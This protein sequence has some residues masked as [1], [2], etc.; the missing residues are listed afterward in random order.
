MA[1]IN[2]TGHWTSSRDIYKGI[3]LQFKLEMSK[4]T[5]RTKEEVL[6]DIRTLAKKDRKYLNHKKLRKIGYGN[7]FYAAVKHFGTWNE[8]ILASGV[9]PLYKKWSKDKVIEEIKGIYEN[10][11]KVPNNGELKRNGNLSLINA[12]YIYWGCWTNAIKAAGFKPYRNDYWTKE[13]LILELKK[14]VS[15]IGHAPSKRELNRFGRFDLVSS[16]SKI[17][18]GYSNYLIAAGFEPVLIPNI[19]TKDRIKEEIIKLSQKIRRTPTERD[20]V[21][22]GLGT[23]K[24]AA[25]R[26]FKSWNAAVK[27]AGLLPNENC[28]KDKIWKEWELFVLS[29]CNYLHPNSKKHIMFPNKCIPDV[30]EPNAKLVIE[31]KINAS[32]STI[33]K[34]IA[35]YDSYC[36]KIEIWHLTGKPIK[37]RSTKVKFVGPNEIRDLIFNNKTFLNKFDEIKNKLEVNQCEA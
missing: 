13:D 32:D 21:S 24:M 14:A 23:V 25:I 9:K 5:I 28:V 19:W 27:S 2:T 10:T 18:G 3:L 31:V 11:G 15:E 33:H 34:D 22:F 30:Y 26:Q 16:G 1:Q 12:A 29:V 8:A 35:N 36:E 4:I 7:L 17:F 6:S 37:V 20:M